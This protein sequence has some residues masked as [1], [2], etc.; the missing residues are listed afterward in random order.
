M[1]IS[2]RQKIIFASY[3]DLRKQEQIYEEKKKIRGE[4]SDSEPFDAH[5]VLFAFSVPLPLRPL[6]P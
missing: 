1:E 2:G 3:A 4:T 5:R 6:L